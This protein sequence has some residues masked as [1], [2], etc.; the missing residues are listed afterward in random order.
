MPSRMHILRFFRDTEARL[1]DLAKR[2]HKD[3][4]L[5]LL[6]IAD[7]IAGHAG[8]LRSELVAEGVIT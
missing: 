1:R 4:P 8:E 5:D 3:I 7:E 2:D 6:T